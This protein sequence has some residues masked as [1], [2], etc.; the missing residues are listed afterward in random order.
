MGLSLSIVLEEEHW[1]I[2]RE[3]LRRSRET[4]RIL[5]IAMLD[6]EIKP[7]CIQPQIFFMCRL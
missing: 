1:T 4:S 7:F 3:K 2:K 5:E 6:T